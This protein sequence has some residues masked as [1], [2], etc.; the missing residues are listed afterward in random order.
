SLPGPRQ[1][2][3]ADERQE[4]F[5]RTFGLAC[6]DTSRP[7]G[8]RQRQGGLERMLEPFLR[9]LVI[10]DDVADAVG[11]AAPTP[12]RRFR[13]ADPAAQLGSFKC[14]QMARKG[15]VG[16]IEEMVAFIEDEP[17]E[18]TRSCFFLLR[19]GN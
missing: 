15:A 14:A 11:E 13:A 7:A 12:T 6:L 10:G 1:H 3:L 16:G 4:P 18:A 2:L 19:L 8:S 9:R 5:C 17:S